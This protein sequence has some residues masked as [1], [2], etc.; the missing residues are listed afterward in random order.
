MAA[1]KIQTATLPRHH[2]RDY[3]KK[4][5]EFLSVMQICL[6]DGQWDAV[7]LNGVHAAISITD[8][9]LVFR[10]GIRST[11]QK[12]DDTVVLV[13]QHIPS[14]ELGGHDVRLSRILNF[15]N[16]VSYQ[17]VVMNESKARQFAKDVERYFEWASKLLL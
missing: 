5:T 16:L 12:H 11:S 9:F 3:Q 2:Y 8:A 1:H 7:V 10:S 17:P 6:N 13:R 15:K 14:K 4:G